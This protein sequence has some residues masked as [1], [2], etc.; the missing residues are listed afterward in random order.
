MMA[1]G[2]AHCQGSCQGMH[3]GNSVGLRITPTNLK[4]LCQILDITWE[5]IEFIP[6]PEKPKTFGEERM[7]QP[8]AYEESMGYV[9]STWL[10]GGRYDVDPVFREPSSS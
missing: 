7:Q 5:E 1:S 8:Q 6:E 3:G 4:K 10:R 2:M 9:D